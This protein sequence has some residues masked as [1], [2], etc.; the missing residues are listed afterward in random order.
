MAISFFH[1]VD[2]FVQFLWNWK[3][4][5]N[6]MV[7]VNTANIRAEICASC[8]N[9]VASNEVKGG[10]GVCNKMGGLVLNSIRDKIISGNRTTSDAKLLTCGICGCDNRI[11]VWIP[12]SVLLANEDAN[13]FP[14]FC[15]KKKILDGSEL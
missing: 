7:D 9:N 11:S 14:S 3:A 5:D 1:K 8:H 15:W 12:N 4:T 2:S 13:A 6:R 10:C